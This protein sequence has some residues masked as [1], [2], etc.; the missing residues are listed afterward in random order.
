VA[1]RYVPTNHVVT[2]YTGRLRPGRWQRDR[3]KRHLAEG[4]K[5]G[6]V[7]D[8]S[9]GG[10]ATREICDWRGV[11]GATGPTV[12]LR[13]PYGVPPNV[14]YGMLLFAEA[15]GL[16]K[17]DELLLDYGPD[18]WT[19]VGHTPTH[20]QH[21]SLSACLGNN[22][23][24]EFFKLW[25]AANAVGDRADFTYETLAFCQ[26]LFDKHE[27][28]LN[29]VRNLGHKGK[30]TPVAGARRGRE[31]RALGGPAP[32]RLE[33]AD[34]VSGGAVVSCGGA[35]GVAPLH[36]G[37]E[38]VLPQVTVTIGNLPA[39]VYQSSKAY[40][41]PYAFFNVLD[42]AGCRLSLAHRRYLKLKAKGPLSGLYMV[43]RALSRM[44]RTKWGATLV[45]VQTTGHATAIDF[46][47]DPSTRGPFVMGD[48]LHAVGI[49]ISDT[50]QL[51]ADAADKHAI[52]LSREALRNH[53]KLAV[54]PPGPEG[55]VIYELKR[56]TPKKS[57]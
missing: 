40:C 21:Y 10:N 47:L 56:L 22:A 27:T 43:A 6:W 53:C 5:E 23:R 45:H 16:K 4:N 41:V 52:P 7:I 25:W 31:M 48:G 18:Y 29:R 20:I 24:A 34:N 39:V 54:G 2:P 49:W 26:R 38:K 30:R 36:C 44:P 46:V 15:P 35:P 13:R 11:P 12:Y 42:L 17:G 14:P 3:L 51:I 33:G 57:K 19:R 55:C 50:Q 28:L 9:E 32:E 8:P 37:A 1:D